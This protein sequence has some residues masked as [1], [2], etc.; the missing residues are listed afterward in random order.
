[1]R[2][3]RTPDARWELMVDRLGE[4]AKKHFAKDSKEKEPWKTEFKERRRLLL[5][6]RRQLLEGSPSGWGERHA[7]EWELCR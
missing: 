2:E 4:A 7:V 1:M 5:Q 6:R 3:D